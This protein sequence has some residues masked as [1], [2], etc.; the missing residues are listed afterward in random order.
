VSAFQL[1]EVTL[2]FDPKV[3]K[4]AYGRRQIFHPSVHSDPSFVSNC[5]YLYSG[6]PCLRL[7]RPGFHLRHP[8]MLFVQ[9][10]ISFFAV[11]S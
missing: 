10:T 3:T 7:A 4:I 1:A 2:H 6:H 8:L 5:H 11:V 9:A